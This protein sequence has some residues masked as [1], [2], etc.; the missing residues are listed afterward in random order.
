MSISSN[1]V[2]G[3]RDTRR[4]T[5]VS[6]DRGLVEQAREHGINISQA[7]ERGIAEQL[8]R[9]RATKWLEENRAAL[10]SSNAYVEAHGLPLARLRQ[11]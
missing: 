4:P 11:F 10:E 3:V 7:C 6:L 2:P 8:A 1:Q 9:V 5:N